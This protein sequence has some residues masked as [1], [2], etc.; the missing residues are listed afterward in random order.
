[1]PTIDTTMRG[2]LLVSRAFPSFEM[3]QELKIDG[4]NL[5]VLQTMFGTYGYRP[6]QSVLQEKD[7]LRLAL[8]ANIG[9]V[10]QTG[11]YSYFALAGD[12]EVTL[13]YDRLPDGIVAELETRSPL[14]LHASGNTIELA[15]RESEEHVLALVGDLL[16]RGRVLRVEVGGASLEDIFVDLMERRDA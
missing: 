6:A 16:K 15:L 13:T 2:T 14:R 5:S 1:M 7:G 11:V 12:C 9:G 10:T 3:K 8:P 4:S